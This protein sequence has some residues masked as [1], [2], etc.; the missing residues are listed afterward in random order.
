[1]VCIKQS[2]TVISCSV[3]RFTLRLTL[4][5]LKLNKENCAYTLSSAQTAKVIIKLTQTYVCSGNI[6][7]TENS[8]P[9]SIKNFV[10]IEDNRFTQP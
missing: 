3:A 4:Q 1:M 5:D 9:K 2:T 7:S 6:I 8:I 10:I